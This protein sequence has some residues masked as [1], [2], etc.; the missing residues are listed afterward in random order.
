MLDKIEETRVLVEGDK[1]GTKVVNMGSPSII[2]VSKPAKFLAAGLFVFL[3]YVIYS[4]RGLDKRSIPDIAKEIEKPP[5]GE[6]KLEKRV[7]VDVYYEALCPDSRYFVIHNLMP[8][9]NKLRDV[10]DVRLWP[11]G[12][13]TTT[14]K[15]GGGFDFRCQ[16]GEEE[17][18]ANM[19]HGCTARYVKDQAT[20]LEMVRC[21]IDDN[22]DAAMAAEKCAKENGV[23]FPQISTCAVGEEGAEIHNMAGLNTN[24]LQPKVSFIPTIKLEDS[25]GSQK[26][27]LKNFLK[28]VCNAYKTKYLEE[29]SECQ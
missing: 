25:Q 15:S 2:Q 24:Q 27:I 16:H 29:L 26:A 28:E 6:I 5:T 4:Y 13:A 10:L 21:M 3:L 9:Y 22:Y 20:R 18:V 12:K 14:N 17:C 8:A 23:S 7:L 1:Q 11:Y 19:W